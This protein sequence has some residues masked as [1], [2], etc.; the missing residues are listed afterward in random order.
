MNTEREPVDSAEW[1][2]PRIVLLVALVLLVGAARPADAH[3]ALLS[4]LPAAGAQVSELDQVVLVFNEQV[5]A[6]LSTVVLTGPRGADAAAGLPVSAGTELVQA[7]DGPLASGAWTVAYR[8]VAAD[9]HPVTGTLGFQ[10]VAP[11]P[12]AVAPSAAPTTSDPRPVRPPPAVA[13]AVT[14]EPAAAPTLP[15]AVGAALVLG[16]GALVARRRS[17][18]TPTP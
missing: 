8:V 16:A 12:Q 14:P 13:T 18:P 4:S 11:P 15:L 2:V 5:Q 7:V 6:G 9:G 3:T 17:R 10:V 1:L